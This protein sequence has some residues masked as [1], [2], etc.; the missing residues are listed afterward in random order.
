M[1]NDLLVAMNGYG[2]TGASA[3]TDYLREFDCVSTNSREFQLLQEPDGI[4]DLYYAL[5]ERK[6]RIGCNTSI[7]RF[8]KNVKNYRNIMFFG[9]NKKKFYSISKQYID[10]LGVISW[11][12][13]S[14]NDSSDVR[15]CFDKNCTHFISR[16]F[17]RVLRIFHLKTLFPLSSK[18]FFCLVDKQTFIQKTE[19]YLEEV[20]DLLALNKKIVALE[21]VFPSLDP[22]RGAE[23]FD[24]KVISIVVERDIRDVFCETNIISN[25]IN[26]YMPCNKDTEM[27]LDYYRT[28]IKNKRS[29]DNSSILYFKF[30]SL[31]NDYDK[32]MNKINE[33]LGLDVSE[34]IHKFEHFEPSRSC[35]NIGIYKNYPQYKDFFEKCER[36]FPDMVY[37]G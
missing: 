2:S 33:L 24:N 29:S 5:V 18:R 28:I 11:K 13:Y 27:F 23:L 14:F 6:S 10:S 31:V 30:E 9:K 7:K 35:K 36:E 12:G 16:C 20:F 4:L 17:N 22:L 1:K 21:Q 19:K 25:D 8:L 32:S 26:R 34:H 37:N 3:I 15:G